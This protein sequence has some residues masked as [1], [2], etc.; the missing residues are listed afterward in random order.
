[1]KVLFLGTPEFAVPTLEALIN[2]KHTVVGVV[3]QPDRAFKRGKTEIG[4]VK[5]VAQNAGLPIFQPQK[6]RNEV[7]TLKTLG[8]D[9]AVTAAYGQILNSEFLDSFEYGVVNVHASLLPKY[10]GASPIQSAIACGETVTGVTIMKTALG[11][12]TGDILSAESVQIGENETMG[13]LSAR[14][15]EIG[16]KLLIYTLDNF[17]NLTPTK[18]NDNFA[19]HCKIIPKEQSYIDFSKSCTA[20]VNQ[21]RSLSPSPCAKTVICGEQYKIFAAKT[22]NVEMCGTVGKI[23]ECSKEKLLIACAQGCI[24]VLEIQAPSK[25]AMKISEFLRGNS[26]KVGV[27]CGK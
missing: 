2:S 18:Q 8:A 21:I 24:E 4:A 26:F 14:L 19:T 15:A 20:V 10:R 25:R 9:I 22:S 5:T 3:T 11:V 23:V 1:M 12:D 27:I 16:A 17:D 13:E 6:I 7:Q